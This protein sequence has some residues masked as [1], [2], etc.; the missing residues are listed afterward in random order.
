M[1]IMSNVVLVHPRACE[2]IPE[3][4]LKVSIVR[5][6]DLAGLHHDLG[7]RATNGLLEAYKPSPSDLDLKASQW[8]PYLTKT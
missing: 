6:L 8:L 2:N 5:L 7:R 1:A 4:R 3:L